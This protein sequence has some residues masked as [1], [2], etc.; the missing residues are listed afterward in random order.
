[1]RMASD[2]NAPE[3]EAQ[4]Q[5]RVMPGGANSE[6]GEFLS[7]DQLRLRTADLDPCE[8]LDLV[9]AVRKRVSAEAEAIVDL[10]GEVLLECQAAGGF[11]ATQLAE[12]IGLPVETPEDRQRSGSLVRQ[13]L[14][15]AHDKR[16]D[17]SDRKGGRPDEYSEV[18]T[19]DR[20]AELLIQRRTVAEI[21]DAYGT[22]T[23]TVTRHLKRHD[24]RSRAI[25][26][27]L[28]KKTDWS[29]LEEL[30][31]IGSS[32]VRAAVAANHVAPASVLEHL[33]RDSDALVRR[34]VAANPRTPVG[35]LDRYLAE[36][37]PDQLTRT[38]ADAATC[39]DSTRLARLL[40]DAAGE[41]GVLVR[42]RAAQRPGLPQGILADLAVDVDASV[43][44]A[45]RA[46]PDFV[47]AV[48][49]H[50]GLMAD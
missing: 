39:Q 21:A 28:S 3:P 6:L 45:A 34:Q 41:D 16:G 47:G 20:L 8:G 1:M 36:N 18:L 37:D 44:A 10:R 38:I 49:A 7:A 26:E 11:N 15:D 24:L 19:R 12:R 43:Q 30:T 9:E 17:R 5:L 48:V 22:S 25:R 29:R 31:R 33:A 27:A 13:W 32:F 46:N 35:T 40:A 2:K 14:K 23:S 4:L 50:A 42:R